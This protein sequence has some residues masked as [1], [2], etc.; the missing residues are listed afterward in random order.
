MTSKKRTRKCASNGGINKMKNLGKK[1]STIVV[2]AIFMLSIVP[3]AFAED[4]TTAEATTA[5][6][7]EAEATTNK[8]KTPKGLLKAT[9]DKWKEVRRHA[10]FVKEE[11]IKARN[12]VKLQ[13]ERLTELKTKLKGCKETN[14]CV[15]KKIEIKE[16]V[17]VHLK[18]TVEMIKKSLDR[19]E[20]KTE[21]STLLSNE[22][23]ESIL[24]KITDLRTR[25]AV[26]ETKIA[27]NLKGAT[28]AEVREEI[29]ILKN[30]WDKIKKEQKWIVLKLTDSKLG[31]VVDKHAEYYNGMKMRIENLADQ[32]IDVSEL[33]HMADKFWDKAKQLKTDYAVAKEA[34]KEV[35]ED[36]SRENLEKA[37]KAQRKVRIGIK[38]TKTALKEF[39][40]LYKVLANQE[41]TT[42]L[43]VETTEEELVEGQCTE[44]DN[45]I[46]YDLKGWA[47][48]YNS[49][50]DGQLSWGDY[51]TETKDGAQTET[52]DYLHESTCIETENGYEVGYLAPVKCVDGCSDGSCVGEVI[53][54]IEIETTESTVPI[55]LPEPN[56]DCVDYDGGRQIYI[57]SYVYGDSGAMVGEF[58]DFCSNHNAGIGTVEAGMSMNTIVVMD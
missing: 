52:G 4:A 18:K 55:S 48:G 23:K 45:G 31:S 16:N 51:C 8:I 34:W 37:K 43:V 24:E 58:T 13:K 7:A 46:D 27:N 35:K 49:Y 12:A 19:F 9:K 44:T 41:E 26:E 14:T 3:V 22:E 50:N 5:A 25:L 29:K 2:L 32:G 21:A 38:D 54:P 6:E 53:E 30:L 10:E 20:E 56:A 15:E 42:E 57:A 33:K 39:I 28:A 40:K 36:P 47:K 17:I 11:Q 1:I